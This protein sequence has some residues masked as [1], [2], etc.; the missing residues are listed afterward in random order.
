MWWSCHH[1][2]LKHIRVFRVY[3]PVPLALP[4]NIVVHLVWTDSILMD[5]SACLSSTLGLMCTLK[6]TLLISI[7]ITMPSSR[8]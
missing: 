2:S 6:P 8:V 1:S 3:I 5:G 4:I 7:T